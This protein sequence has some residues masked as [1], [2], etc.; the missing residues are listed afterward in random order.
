MI[1]TQA[2][3]FTLPAGSVSEIVTENSS[4]G[5]FPRKSSMI[6]TLKHIVCVPSSNGIKVSMTVV[7][8]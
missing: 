8:L 6:D 5:S 2:S 3:E 7:E 1:V 4:S